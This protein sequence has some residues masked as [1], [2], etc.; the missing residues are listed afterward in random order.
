MN[1]LANINLEAVNQLL[2]NKSLTDKDLPLPILK[3]ANLNKGVAIG[4][5]SALPLKAFANFQIRH[6]ELN[7]PQ[8]Q[9]PTDTVIKK[10]LP[11]K[12]NHSWL[13]YTSESKIDMDSP[14]VIKKLGISFDLDKSLI[15]NTYK[16]HQN[17]QSVSAA[18]FQD[19]QSFATL[20]FKQQVLENLGIGEAVSMQVVGKLALGATVSFSEIFAGSLGNLANLLAPNQ[21]LQL[22][23]GATASA[24]FDISVKDE[25][26]LAI[27]KISENEFRISLKK[28]VNQSFN[29]N[30]SA[31]V[32][33]SLQNPAML[34]KALAPAI[35][36]VFNLPENK[37]KELGDKVKADQWLDEAEKQAL[38]MIATRLG[39]S[40]G[41]DV[42]EIANQIE[43]KKKNI[44]QIITQIAQ[45]KV[46][47][48]F[49]FEYQRLSTEDAFLQAILSKEVLDKHYNN[50]IL[51]RF[52]EVL[53]NIASNPNVKI[54]NYLNEKSFKKQ[55][56][57][58]LGLDF[59]QWGRL[60]GKDKESISWTVRENIS[61]QKQ[62][63]FLGTRLYQSEEFKN[64][65][66]WGVNFKAEMP[67]FSANNMPTAQE[68]QYEWQVL[69]EQVENEVTTEEVA[70]MV[71]LAVLW[72]MV[73]EA[74]A[75][76]YAQ[77]LFLTL[78]NAKQVTF[79][80]QLVVGN[81]AFLKIL[82]ILSKKINN[83]I[84]R[85]LAGGMNYLQYFNSRKSVS[86][87]AELYTPLWRTYL[88][89]Y[90][91]GAD[92]SAVAKEYLKDKDADLARYE[93]DYQKNKTVGAYNLFEG[94][95]DLNPNTA[96]QI[97]SFVAGANLLLK[98]ISSSL[99]YNQI[100]APSFAQMQN[101]CT[102]SHHI[103]SLGFH[104]VEMAKNPSVNVF[105]LLG[106][107][108]SIRY[109]LGNE[110]KSIQVTKS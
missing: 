98:G 60:A 83:L 86:K 64:K 26:S 91:D 72:G 67:N 63:S 81:E 102:Q 36:S 95:I 94:L 1:L 101:F 45:T 4:E 61:Q 85:G 38:G 34:T 96:T 62:V 19:V 71:D 75:E 20:V 50:L 44:L 90:K 65:V 88:E 80:F 54:E 49:S 70:Q 92:W 52:D 17:T 46:K 31:S 10:M 66:N 33:V 107:T 16:L 99:P 2:A 35:E 53:Q 84:A 3:Q 5:E 22:R 7:V 79:S 40:Q 93:G 56:S 28:A 87:R 15:F 76:Q 14:E 42:K 6:F 82:P 47:A 68:F 12:E 9:L 89:K 105:P 77:D 48:G 27:I 39:L 100:I 108:F 57:W 103:R 41:I 30:L 58:G 73:S 104:L 37:L 55:V 106:R 110:Q 13:A 8:K 21:N 97:D 51:F 78:E 109:G 32:E 59:G 29:A 11:T 43:A 24:D 25:F 18:L 23:I 69:W 74:E